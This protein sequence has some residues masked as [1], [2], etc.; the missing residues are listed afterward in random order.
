MSEAR[1]TQQVP[2]AIVDDLMAAIRNAFYP[3]NPVWFKQRSFIK[4]HVV[5]WPATW[6]IERGVTL[7]AFRYKQLV[8]EVV[9]GVK[10]HGNTDAVKF[11]PGYLKQCLQSHFAM[12]GDEIYEEA[13]AIRGKIQ[14]ALE[15]CRRSGAAAIDPISVIAMARKLDRPKPRLKANK[16]QLHLL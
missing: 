7:S 13:K 11:W 4:R 2:D 16:Q 5:C 10:Q 9:M 14:S 6:L 3:G 1:P 15:E 8:L 12:H